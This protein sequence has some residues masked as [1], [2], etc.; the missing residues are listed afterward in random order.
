V[1]LAVV[2]D[3][4]GGRGGEARTGFAAQQAAYE[5]IQAARSPYAGVV[6]D[7]RR[8]PGGGPARPIDD[9]VQAGGD[10]E[11]VVR[12]IRAVLD[13]LGEWA[14]VHISLRIPFPEPGLDHQLERLATFGREI[15]PRLRGAP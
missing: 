13:R 7:E 10:A 12:G 1:N 3:A 9:H 4:P 6:R 15:L 8:G 5:R 2:L 14:S 11:T